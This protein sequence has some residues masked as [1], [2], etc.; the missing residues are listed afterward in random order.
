MLRM[1]DNLPPGSIT[2]SGWNILVIEY[3]GKLIEKFLGYSHEDN[4]FRLSSQVLEYDPETNTGKTESGSKYFFRDKPGS[5]HPLALSYFEQ[6]STYDEVS[7]H[8]K[9]EG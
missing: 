9:F 4:H 5:L 1:I 3:Q 7:V 6:I 8:L 2:M